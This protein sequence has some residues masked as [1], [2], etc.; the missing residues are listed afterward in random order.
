LKK[1]TLELTAEF[2]K[3]YGIKQATFGASSLSVRDISMVDFKGCL[4]IYDI[5]KGKSK[6][7][8]QAH[9]GIANTIDGIGGK[10]SEYGAPELV[11]GGSDG[12]VRVWDP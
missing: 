4:D 7:H 1:G 2:P 10:G 3:D 8:V 11:T 6:Y 5:E 9:T 12:C